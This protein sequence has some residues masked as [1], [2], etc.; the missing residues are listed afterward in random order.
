MRSGAG[1]SSWSRTRDGGWPPPAA[2][3]GKA[4][5][6]RVEGAALLLESMVDPQLGLA[7][8]KRVEA[9]LREAEERF[10]GAFEVA[11]IGMAIVAAAIAFFVPLSDRKSDD[12]A[13]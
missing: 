3:D 10:Q 1:S 11:P 2:F 13:Q 12:E 7:A 8:R 4:W 6:A 5:A 9:E